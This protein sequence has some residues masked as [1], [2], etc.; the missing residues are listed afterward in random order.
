MKDKKKS[1]KIIINFD[2]FE[3]EEKVFYNVLEWLKINLRDHQK[4]TFSVEGEK[5]LKFPEDA[6]DLLKPRVQ[7]NNSGELGKVAERESQS[8]I[9]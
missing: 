5:N 3:D 2:T 4:A 8:K 1:M 6:K 9:S 7:E